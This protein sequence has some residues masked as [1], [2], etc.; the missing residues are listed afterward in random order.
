MTV[1]KRKQGKASGVAGSSGL[2]A[3]P[4]TIREESP[5]PTASP[6]PRKKSLPDL[7]VNPGSSLSSAKHNGVARKLSD[8]ALSTQAVNTN[9]LPR[10]RKI[11]L[12]AALSGAPRIMADGSLVHQLNKSTL[13]VPSENPDSD[14][15]EHEYSNIADT[16]AYLSERRERKLQ[17]MQQEKTTSP[18]TSD[19][20]VESSSWTAKSSL[21]GS[22]SLSQ[23]QQTPAGKVVRSSRGKPQEMQSRIRQWERRLSSDSEDSVSSPT[24][25]K[26]I[27]TPRAS[28]KPDLKPKPKLLNGQNAVPPRPRTSQIVRARGKV[29]DGAGA[30]PTTHEEQQPSPPQEPKMPQRPRGTEIR[31][32]RQQGVQQFNVPPPPPTTAPSPSTTPTITATNDEGDHKVVLSSP[33]KSAFRPVSNQRHRSPSPGLAMVREERSGYTGTTPSALGLRSRSRSPQV[34][35]K[36]PSRSPSPSVTSAGVSLAPPKPLR[37]DRTQSE[38]DAQDTPTS[39]ASSSPASS[40]MSGGLVG[41]GNEEGNPLNQQMAETLIKY[42]LA[43]QDSGLKDALR[44][45]IM[46]NPEAVKALKN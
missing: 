15:E 36:S 45:C 41:I 28:R 39:P 27:A 31:R 29:V 44:D 24:T 26:P 10:Q 25:R 20:E 8:S 6:Q 23:Q 30:E 37:K 35:R 33:D 13:G 12:N 38:S 4:P 42:V 32:A 3:S 7:R 46:S 34:R 40:P 17:E 19:S 43:S 2:K 16:E 5:P 21:G 11:P 9:N 18:P 22:S 1:K 14:T